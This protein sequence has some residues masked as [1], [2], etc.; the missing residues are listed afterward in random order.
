MYSST[1]RLVGVVLS[2]M[3]LGTNSSRVV[4]DEMNLTSIP[5]A[6]EPECTDLVINDNNIPSLVE[7]A[8]ISYPKLVMLRL[9]SN[10]IRNV[11]D[12]VFNG[13]FALRE[14]SMMYN[15]IVYLP[16][17]LGP[18]TTSL[19]NLNLWSAFR[20][21]VRPPISHP[22]FTAF[23]SL[24]TL[25][26]GDTSHGRFNASLL[27]K[28]LTYINFAY[29]RLV[30]FPDFSSHAPNL[31][32]IK[33]YENPFQEIPRVYLMG[34]LHIRDLDIADNLL[35]TVPDLYHIDFKEFRVAGNPLECNQ[36]LCWIRMWPWMKSPVLM[37]T[38]TCETPVSLHGKPLME[39]AP[40]ALQCYKGEWMS[41]AELIRHECLIAWGS[42]LPFSCY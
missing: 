28:N 21:G 6:S 14:L 31:K 9:D 15:D 1:G 27:P 12:G 36:S 16:S 2:A 37:D 35:T 4:Y 10:K 17:T 38:P 3:L 32:E 39:I 11:L 25:N 20:Y 22:F 30:E 13:V 26:L 19:T 42:I 7:N 8:F 5:I 29:A 18:P 41:G 40:T 23:V 24:K 33:V 34:M